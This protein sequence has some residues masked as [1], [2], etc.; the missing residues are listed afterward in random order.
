MGC[1]GKYIEKLYTRMVRPVLEY[2]ITAWATTSNT[3]FYK[4]NKVLNYAAH[5][6]TGA[7]TSR[8]YDRPPTNGGQK[9]LEGYLTSGIFQTIKCTPYV[10]ENAWN[11][12]KLT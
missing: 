9:R 7:I 5:I 4:I 2:G 11:Q 6:I 8:N 12:K 1:L 10:R 3:Q